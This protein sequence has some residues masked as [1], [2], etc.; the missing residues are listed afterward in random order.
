MAIFEMMDPTLQPA[1]SATGLAPR[2]ADLRGKRL[3]LMDNGKPNADRL[4][5]EIYAILEP[6][7]QPSSVTW[8]TVPTTFPASDELLDEIAAEC[9]LVIEAVGSCGSCSAAS[10]ADVILMERRGIPSAA[11]CTDALKASADS[12]A[13]IQGMPGYRYA[14]V[15]HPMSSIDPETVASHARLAAPQVLAILKATT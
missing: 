11:I 12:M 4:L 2:P 15:P 8:K 5:K 6:E 14:V 13:R 1:K 9:D 7:L 10:V 3:V